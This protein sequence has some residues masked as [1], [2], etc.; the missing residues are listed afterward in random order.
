[1]AVPDVGAELESL[2]QGAAVCADIVGDSRAVLLGMSD[3]SMQLYSWHAQVGQKAS[4]FN[5]CSRG[6][7]DGELSCRHQTL[8]PIGITVSC[9]TVQGQRRALCAGRCGQ[10]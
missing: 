3:G 5:I 8:T 9:A 1:M 7:P 2:L 4:C 10:R 6:G